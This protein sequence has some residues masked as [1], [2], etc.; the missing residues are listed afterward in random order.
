M[1]LNSRFVILLILTYLVSWFQL[2]NTLHELEEC[3][4]NLN[5]CMEDNAKLSR[6]EDCVLLFYQY[7]GSLVY[8]VSAFILESLILKVIYSC[9]FVL[10]HMLQGN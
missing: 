7:M 4:R 5:N 8:L 6:L 10:S 3:R 2:K 9:G 1:S